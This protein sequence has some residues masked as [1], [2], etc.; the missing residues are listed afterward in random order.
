M[1][2]VLSLVW[3]A[4]LIAVVVLGSARLMLYIGYAPEGMFGD[5][6]RDVLKAFWLG[7][8]FDLKVIGSCLAPLLL[9]EPVFF[10]L[11]TSWRVVGVRLAK[12][13][14]VLF[15]LLLLALSIGNYFY[16]GFYHSPFD[17]IV[18]G[19]FEDDTAAIIKSIWEDYPVLY[20]FLGLLVFTAGISW[21]LRY[22]PDPLVDGRFVALHFIG[23]FLLMLLLARGSLGIFPLRAMDLAVSDN[24][25]INH[26]VP[27]GAYALRQ[28]WRDRQHTAIGDDPDIGLKKY[29]FRHPQDAAQILGLNATDKTDL[30]KSFYQR[31]PVRP[32]LQ[33]HPPNVVIALMESD[34]RHLLSYHQ[35]SNNLLGRFEKYVQEGTLLMH[36]LAAQNGTHPSLEAMLFNTAITP[37]TRGQYG[38]QLLPSS[39]I[40][41][42]KQ[43]GYRTIFVSSGPKSW[44]RLGRVLPRQGFDEVYGQ[45]D[46]IKAIP[47]TQSS[48]WG[49]YD[50]YTF[51]FASQLMADA[52]QPVALFILPVTNHTPHTLPDNY[53]PYPLDLSVFKGHR[54]K[55]DAEA[56]RILMTYQYA[57]DALGGFM[58]RLRESGLY[59]QTLVAVT[60]DHN[61]RNFFKYSGETELDYKF[62]VPIF[63]HIPESYLF[64]ESVDL[65]RYVSHRDIFPTLY[66]H[67][68]SG[69]EYLSPGGVDVLDPDSQHL[70]AMNEFRRVVYSGGA[71]SLIGK[72][73][74]LRWDEDGQLTLEKNPDKA[75]LA[76]REKNRAWAAL[77][78]WFIRYQ[79][80]QQDGSKGYN[81][82][83]K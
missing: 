16:F 81:H 65:N 79:L 33:A 64:S 44:R 23:T 42:F 40:L 38:F 9:L 34:G 57:N 56:L 75:M 7:F 11:P 51:Q 19:L 46:I 22:K 24:T 4:L 61:T 27:N 43:A 12:G 36:G 77:M 59:E 26:S 39:A 70:G 21:W 14:I 29:G 48:V 32:Q 74:F 13:Y 62:G 72:D 28:A 82:S 63:F 55:E 35:A 71:M 78:E 25:F 80:L 6:G 52:E 76:I 31:T 1:H 53:R 50:D 15:L 54:P 18:F 2:E 37:L 68:L 45:A 66:H 10:L 60:G 47:E 20:G 83:S 8:R 69:A 58:D 5:E 41:P 3:R 73:H 30:A 49:A 67:A 17:P